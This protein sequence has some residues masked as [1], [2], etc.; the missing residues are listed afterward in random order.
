MNHRLQQSISA[1]NPP[2]L[3]SEIG[4]CGGFSKHVDSI[5]RK[6]PKPALA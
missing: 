6:L 1:Q 4:N 2:V 3:G 5:N